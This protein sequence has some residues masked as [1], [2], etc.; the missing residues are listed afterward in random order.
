MNS[1]KEYEK[2]LKYLKDNNLEHLIDKE[3]S[4]DGYT[5]VYLARQIMTERGEDYE[6]YF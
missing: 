6:K 5:V 1:D 3:M 2:A 4:T